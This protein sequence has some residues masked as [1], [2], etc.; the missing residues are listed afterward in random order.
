MNAIFSDRAKEQNNT[1][2]NSNDYNSVVMAT[3][4]AI[5]VCYYVR[6]SD[7]DDY[8]EQ[9]AT[10]FRYHFI[11]TRFRRGVVGGTQIISDPTQ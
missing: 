9:V 8:L 1:D 3:I 7:R 6:V 11:I 2:V 5:G 10:Y 4:N